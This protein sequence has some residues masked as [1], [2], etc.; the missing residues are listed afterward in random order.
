MATKKPAAAPKR[1]PVEFSKEENELVEYIKSNELTLVSYERLWATLMAC[2][3]AI[4]QGIDGD[5]VECGV[6]R[7]GNA[8]L[9]AEIFRM[10][11][12]HD[13]KVYMFDTFKGMTPPTE[14]DAKISTG[15]SVL[16]KFLSKQKDDHNE[17]YYASLDQVRENFAKRG[18]L[19]S[20]VIFVPGDVLQTLDGR[21]VPARIS[22][23]RLDTDWYES[24][25]KE[26]EVLYPRLSLGGTLIVDDYGHFA[27]SKKAV[28]EYF[29]RTGKRPLLTCSDYTGRIGVKCA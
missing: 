17:M 11:K 12:A 22:V 5:F 14:A 19:A 18:L 1:L 23:L 25:R 6:W 2:K 9:A 13:R 24:T 21:E 7:G 10:Y 8:L 27:G 16:P 4:E 20:N 26:L 29:G 3:H 28:D 15:E